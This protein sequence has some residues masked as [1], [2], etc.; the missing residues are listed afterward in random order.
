MIVLVEPELVVAKLLEADNRRY[1]TFQRLL[2]FVAY[3]NE[4]LEKMNA[5][6]ENRDIKCVVSF[7]SIRRALEYEYKKY[8]IIGDTVVLRK[9]IKDDYS[10]G[11][12]EL[13]NTITTITEKFAE[14]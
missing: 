7:S 11:F 14:L 12:P 13:Y 1:F 8:D 5:L 9:E 4:Q 2:K 10:Q 3:L 6:P